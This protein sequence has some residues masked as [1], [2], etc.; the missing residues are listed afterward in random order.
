MKQM[1]RSVDYDIGKQKQF[2]IQARNFYFAAKRCGRSELIEESGLNQN[3]LIPEC[4]NI[5]FSCELYL[6]ALLFKNQ[7]IIREHSLFGLYNLLDTA[8]KDEIFNCMKM[9]P[10]QLGLLIKQHSEL[11]TK[12]RYRFEYPQ[13]KDNF[14]VPLEFFYN[15]AESLDQI[16]RRYIGIEPYPTT[17][18]G[19]DEE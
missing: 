1:S 9:G 3:L 16:A 10:D 12:M 15:I 7:E 5:A 18:Y 19:I 8:T 6:K 11:F 14:T 2:Y 17:K 4:V 13:Y